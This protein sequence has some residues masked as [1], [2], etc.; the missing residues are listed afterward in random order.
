LTD[1]LGR[2]RLHHRDACTHAPDDPEFERFPAALCARHAPVRKVIP[3]TR[4]DKVLVIPNRAD[5]AIPADLSEF[6]QVILEK[7]T[8]DV[9]D[10]PNTEKVIERVAGLPARTQKFSCSAWS[11]EYCVRFAAKDCSNAGGAWRW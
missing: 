4:A 9:F 6:Q 7:Q 11:P 3:E 10:N 8:L 5:A 1:A 2:A